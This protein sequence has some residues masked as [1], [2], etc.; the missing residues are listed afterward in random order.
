M[1]ASGL[2]PVVRV[3][4]C[5]HHAYTQLLHVQQRLGYDGELYFVSCLGPLQ[6]FLGLW[7]RSVA[8]LEAIWCDVCTFSG[9]WTPLGSF[10]GPRWVPHWVA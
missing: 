4:V 8:P 6:V 3:G 1:A 9:F 10:F 2:S 7:K 5:T